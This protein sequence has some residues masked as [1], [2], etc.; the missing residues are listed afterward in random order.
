MNQ[1]RVLFVGHDAKRTGAPA[2][3]LQLMRWMKDHC[4]I[5]FSLLLVDGGPLEEEYKKLCA[6][7]VL[8]GGPDG[9]V[10][11]TL[12]EVRASL[13]LDE[14]GLVYA[15]TIA[16]G[17]AFDLAA[18]STVPV[19]THVHELESVIRLNWG[20]FR[21][22]RDRTDR[23]LAVSRQVAENLTQTHGIP[24][25]R[26]ER[27]AEFID[28]PAVGGADRSHQALRLRE[29]LG[30]PP[31]SL[32]VGGVGTSDL[33]K[34]TDLFCE[35]AKV[36]NCSAGRP[37]HFV[38]IGADLRSDFV[39]RL[40][41]ALG[42]ELA[43][44]VHWMPSRPDAARLIAGFDVFALTSREDPFPLVMLESAAAG[45]PIVCFDGTGGA[46]EFVSGGC[47]LAAPGLDPTAM[48]REIV[49]IL[50]SEELR[51][52][53]RQNARR[54]VAEEHDVAAVAPR[55]VSIIRS[56]LA[57]PPAFRDE[58]WEKVLQLSDVGTLR[59]AGP[60]GSGA[61][62]A[63]AKQVLQRLRILDHLSRE[64]GVH[65]QFARSCY[66]RLVRNALALLSRG[67]LSIRCR[68]ALPLRLGWTAR[69]FPMLVSGGMVRL[70]RAKVARSAGASHDPRP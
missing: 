28:V 14:V 41:T 47:G 15:N 11:Q 8:P 69:R 37:V 70:A 49:Q 1:P 5:R 64:N 10:H 33:R 52:N 12:Q 50:D 63:A 62:E 40:Q 25:K 45:T 2:V 9:V 35:V 38:W 43:P 22:V 68:L 60:F 7:R 59:T 54:K 26:I 46:A 23:F 17:P 48:A 53:L 21:M 18:W 19:L 32:V 13:R 67:G 16:T 24:E 61:H 4:E 66:R 30:L 42:P 3:L 65:P 56:M 39:Q 58:L 44:R 6:T 20:S 57:P 51:R 36:V 55:I 34:G 29:E 27:V 31:E